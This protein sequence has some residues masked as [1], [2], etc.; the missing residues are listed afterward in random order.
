MVKHTFLCKVDTHPKLSLENIFFVSRRFV[1][2]LWPL[3]SPKL[4]I[5]SIIKFNYILLNESRAYLMPFKIFSLT[6]MHL[7]K[8]P[9]ATYIF[10]KILLSI[11]R[12]NERK[13]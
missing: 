9:I 4:A 7:P 1:V 11:L 12:P 6:G 8:T 3:I 2:K 13:S 10:E 5:A